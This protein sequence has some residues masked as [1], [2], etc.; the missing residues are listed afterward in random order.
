M[1]TEEGIFFFV[2]EKVV[3]VFSHHMASCSDITVT[4]VTKLSLYLEV[5]RKI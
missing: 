4:P 2:N 1:E 5:A 3:G